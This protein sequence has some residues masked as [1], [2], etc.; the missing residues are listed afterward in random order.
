MQIRQERGCQKVNAVNT[1]WDSWKRT[2]GQAVEYAEEMG[3]SK[4]HINSMARQLGDILA[5]KVPPANP[6]QKAVKELWEVATP[7]ERQVLTN[8]MTKLSGNK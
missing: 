7:E 5:E 2:L 3:I 6:E 1:S 8:L 4:E